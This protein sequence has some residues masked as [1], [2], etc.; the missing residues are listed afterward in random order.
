MLGAVSDT[1]LDIDSLLAP[2]WPPVGPKDNKCSLSIDAAA[3]LETGHCSLSPACTSV[4]VYDCFL[5]FALLAVGLRLMAYKT[6]VG[7][8]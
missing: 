5:R 3:D 7:A 1:F 2:C 6:V 8:L 4:S